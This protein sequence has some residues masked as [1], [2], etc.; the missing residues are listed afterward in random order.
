[1]SGLRKFIFLIAIFFG[2]PFL[3]PSHG[4]QSV[5]LPTAYATLN[6]GVEIGKWDE[7]RFEV[8]STDYETFKTAAFGYVFAGQKNCIIKLADELNGLTGIKIPGDQDERMRRSPLKLKFNESVKLLIGAFQDKG[9]EYRQFAEDK[10]QKLVLKNAVTVTGLPPVDVYAL[11]YKKGTHVI[12][13]EGSGSF[14]VLGVIRAGQSITLRDAGMPDGKLWEPFIVEGFYNKTPLIEIIGGPDKPV[15]EEGM[16]GTEGIQGG[17]EGGMCVKIGDTYHMFPT[18]RAGQQGVEAYYDRVKTRIGHWT[19]KDAIHW[20]RRSTIYQASGTYAVT[21]DDNPLNERRGAIWSYMPVFSEKANRWYGYYLAYTVHKEIEPNHSFGRIWRTES[22]KE[23]IDGI[24]GPYKDAG[25]IMEPGLDTQLWE[26]RQGVDSFFPFQVGNEW[27]GFYGGAYPF[28]KREDYPRKSKKAWYVGLAKSPTLEGPWTRLDTTVNPV[29]SIHPSFIE[30]PIV[31]K[32]QD[33][34]FITIFDGGPEAW[35]LH[36][37]NMMGYAL[38]TD[39][40]HWSEAHYLPIHTKVKQ[41]WTIMR[42]PVC[43]IPE[44]NDVYTILYAA[45]DATRR[46]HPMGMVKVRLNRKVQ[47]SMTG[48]F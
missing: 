47:D 20:T 9:N 28:E 7:A 29:T 24:G 10:N 15:L 48:K 43:L 14:I 5:A 2:V 36:L 19:S 31:Y 39:G 17:F 40:Y 35:G 46:F 11:E 44:G 38:S 30:N 42:T 16:P 1:M 6:P 32:L 18:E 33:N 13:P 41:W 22:I 27:L 3:N 45:I 37:P 4:S 23:G 8:L 25:I 21:D 12:N 34:L 26:G